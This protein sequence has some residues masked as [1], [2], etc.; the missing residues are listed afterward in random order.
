M[1]KDQ[2]VPMKLT[3]LAVSLGAGW[4]AQKAV[5]ALWTKATGHS[6][7]TTDDD[8]AT[9][10]SIVAFAAVTSATAALTRVLAS[11]STSRFAKRLS[12]RKA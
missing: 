5:T 10:A 12:A 11:R 7:V 8:D 9:V 3:T 2:S 4:V 6:P 1:A